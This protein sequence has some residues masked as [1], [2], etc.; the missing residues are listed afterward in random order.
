MS[1]PFPPPH[2]LSMESSNPGRLLRRAAS[3]S[4]ATFLLLGPFLPLLPPPPLAPSSSLPSVASPRPFGVSLFLPSPR[5]GRADNFWQRRPRGCRCSL[6]CRHNHTQTEHAY[7]FQF[8]RVL[9]LRWLWVACIVASNLTL[10][11]L[12]AP[13][14]GRVLAWCRLSFSSG[15]VSLSTP[16]AAFVGPV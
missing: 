9:L 4:T 6:M 12:R 2:H 1:T 3:F 16:K 5:P 15:S 10:E 14:T 11:L 13:S 8:V 7:R